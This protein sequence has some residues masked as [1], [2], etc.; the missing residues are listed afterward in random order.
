MALSL[1]LGLGLQGAPKDYVD[2]YMARQKG[3]AAA[4]QK[5]AE[6]KAKELEP[7]KKRLLDISGDDYLP[8]GKS[9]VIDS[10]SETLDFAVNNSGDLAEVAKKFMQ[11]N[12]LAQ[13]EKNERAMVKKIETDRN[14]GWIPDNVLNLVRNESDPKKLADLNN[15]PVSPFKYDETTNKITFNPHVQINITDDISKTLNNPNYYD[16][17]SKSQTPIR[18]GQRDMVM[19]GLK[20][21][22][23]QL[24]TQKLSDPNYRQSVRVEYFENLKNLNTLPDFSTPQGRADFDKGA[25]NFLADKVQGQINNFTKV[26]SGYR[27]QPST[28]NFN[29]G[30]DQ[31]SPAA[32]QGGNAVI[33]KVL[34]PPELANLGDKNNFTGSASGLSGT[35]A[36]NYKA[37]LPISGQTFDLQ[38]GKE[39][40]KADIIDATYNQ[41]DAYYTLKKDYRYNATPYGKTP[42][43]ITLKKGMIIPDD[44][45]DRAKKEGVAD[46][47]VLTFGI[48]NDGR[49]KFYSPVA[50][51][52]QSQL[53]ALSKDERA[54]YE[55]AIREREAL[56]K[57]VKSSLGGSSK[58]AAAAPKTA[59]PTKTASKRASGNTALQQLIKAQ[60]GK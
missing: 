9:R 33:V 59:A 40:K 26:L 5:A 12:M 13:E 28:F 24:F 56:V 54:I 29:M 34:G 37:S 30:G 36:V 49:T 16:F 8:K 18:I 31:T 3:K 52:N 60:T 53:N 39:I 32:P 15:N 2:V 1:A 22:A 47:S 14:Y 38:T 10:A 27:G 42:N 48:S 20:P 45:I 51:P 57:G 46:V 50:F 7:I 23:A 21:E 25:E 44:F 55:S 35:A 11:T 6:A 17:T 58:P 41:T 19:V 4:E 43:Y